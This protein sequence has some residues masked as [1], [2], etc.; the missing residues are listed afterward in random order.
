[1]I[2]CPRCGELVSGDRELCI[3]CGRPVPDPAR[4]VERRLRALVIGAFVLGALMLIGQMI[5]DSLAR[6]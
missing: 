3:G 2:K 4:P 1:M 6:P 5:R